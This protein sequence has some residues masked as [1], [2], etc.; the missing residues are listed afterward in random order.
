MR[1]HIIN[2]RDPNAA[3][4]LSRERLEAEL[5]LN[6]LAAA[7][8]EISE[9]ASG[10]VPDDAEVV[11]TCVKPD[12]AALKSSMP[13]L[14]WVQVISAGVEA[15]L[16]TLPDDVLLTNASGVHGDKGGEFVLAAALMLN[17]LIPGF[18]SDK[19]AR[20]WQPV[21]ATPAR[22]KTVTLL[23]VGGI[24]REA[25]RR[26]RQN[27]FHVTGVTRGGRADVDLD[28]VIS[29]D[30]LDTV[31]ASTDILAST[32]PLTPETQNVVDRRRLEMLPKH[33]GVV[34][35]GRA[36][37]VDYAVM[38]EMLS[39]GRLSGAVLDVFPEEPLPGSDA[40]WDCPNLIMTPHC[41]VDDHATYMEGCLGIFIDNLKRFARGE[42][43]RNQIDPQQGY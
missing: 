36:A 41:S 4:G 19:A 17:Y 30:H 23:G 15:I 6:S 32:L 12:V 5:S 34:V 21:F 29:V 24:G 28:A 8:Y 43:L 38:A 22:G 40:L 13:S 35:V 20:R 31:L 1:I 37:V 14:R 2:D 16:P 27:G 42:M 39:A 25:A 26:L 10:A 7:D 33:A 9:G 11:F 3:L 18:V